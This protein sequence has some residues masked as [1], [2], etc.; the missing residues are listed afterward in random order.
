MDKLQHVIFGIYLFHYH[1][2]SSDPFF[3]FISF[4]MYLFIE[5]QPPNLTHQN[6]SFV[7]VG[8]VSTLH[9]AISPVVRTV[10]G[11]SIAAY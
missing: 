3:V 11:I 2:L 6:I 7:R 5:Y 1:S 4:T 8:N 10:P 9:A